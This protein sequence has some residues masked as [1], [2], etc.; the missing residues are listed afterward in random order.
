MT[1]QRKLGIYEH[2]SDLGISE[3]DYPAIIAE[4]LNSGSMKANPREAK[5]ED[6]INILNEST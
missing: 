6:L 2:I 3:E 4:S 1:L 5:S